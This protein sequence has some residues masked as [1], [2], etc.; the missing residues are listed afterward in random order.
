M[1][2]HELKVF[3]GGDIEAAKRA[4]ALRPRPISHPIAHHAAPA[5]HPDDAELSARF[6]GWYAGDL[7]FVNEQ[8][9]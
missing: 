8:P 4:H 1:L 6:A 3:Y 7:Q 2:E 5:P 9:H